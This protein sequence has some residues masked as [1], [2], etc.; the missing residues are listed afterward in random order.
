[1][2]GPGTSAATRTDMNVM[3]ADILLLSVQPE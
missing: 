2:T 3:S 1:M